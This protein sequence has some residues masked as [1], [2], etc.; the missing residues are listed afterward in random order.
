MILLC[1][2]YT[3]LMVLFLLINFGEIIQSY[4]FIFLSTIFL[5]LKVLYL[6]LV[7]DL[8]ELVILIVTNWQVN[9]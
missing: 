9:W 5:N 1:N 2:M 7:I 3:I 4:V 8:K 6:I